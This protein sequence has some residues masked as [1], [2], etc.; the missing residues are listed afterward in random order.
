MC[1]FLPLFL[2]FDKNKYKNSLKTNEN[3]NGMKNA[4]VPIMAISL[5]SRVGA[6]VLDDH[7]GNYCDGL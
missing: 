5:F 2:N 1:E 7:S 4:T 6:I 3:D